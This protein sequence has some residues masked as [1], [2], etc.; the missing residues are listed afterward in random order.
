MIGYYVHHQGHGHLARA[1]AVADALDEPVTGLSSLAPPADW[2]GEWVQ[3]PIDD[4][5]LNAEDHERLDVTARG[6]LHWVPRGHEGLRT[7]VA[8]MSAWI[9][10]ARP[11]VVVVDV[12][13]EVVALVRLHGV[14]VASFVVPGERG[15]AAHRLG[16][17]LSDA[18][19]GCWPPD[20]VG[21]VRGV[22]AEVTDRI[23]AVG[24]LSR[25]PVVDP[26]PRRPGPPRVT[27]LAGTGGSFAAHDIE[28]AR[29][30]TLEWEWS[31]LDPA[32]TGWVADPYPLVTDADVVV[33]HAGQNAVAE[34]A[35]ARRPAIVV[36]QVRP[37]DEQRVA[38]DVLAQGPWP[39]L[40]V[41]TFVDQ[42]WERLL[43][44]ASLMDG[45]GWASWCDG[46]EAARIAQAV[47]RAG[48]MP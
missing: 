38:G 43:G 35:S 23:E 18:L 32:L 12:S 3:L 48:G 28:L 20:A 46:H 5:D 25:F 37:H 19:I 26:A 14:P 27:L 9:A 29:K 33:T 36:P 44:L 7:R 47:R 2:A 31:V 39:V 17:D 41:D 45:A 15:D 16:F 42:E 30:A 6:R 1:L 13:V 4:T 40:V 8:L 24:A 34:V 10:S 21:I 11:D 22:P